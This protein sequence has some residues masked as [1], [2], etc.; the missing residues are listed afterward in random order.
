MAKATV[1]IKAFYR[2]PSLYSPEAL[3]AANVQESRPTPELW[4]GGI[5]AFLFFG[6][7]L[8]GA[9]LV[10]FD[11]AALGPGTLAVAGHRQTVQHRDGGSISALK[12]K[13]GQH[14]T[15]GQVLLEL[16]SA[17]VRNQE[18]SLAAQV[19]SLKAQRARLEAEVNGAAAI[20]WPV[21]F[22]ALSGA[23]RELALSAQ[24]L[25]Q[26]QFL[27]RATSMSAQRRVLGQR[28]VELAHQVE[29]YRGQ[30][31]SAERQ[32]ALLAEQLAS[33][34]ALEKQGYASVN[35]TRSL[36]R[37]IAAV[38]GARAQLSA[39]RL[40]TQK[41]IGEMGLQ[42]V[43]NDKRYGEVSSQELRDTLFQL[44]E[45][46]PKFR[47]AQD[48]LSRLQVKAPA[49][50]RVVGL[51]VFTVGGVISPGQSLMDIVPD[52]APLVVRA[53]FAPTDID[54]IRIGQM[55]EVRFASVHDRDLPMVKGAITNLSADALADEKTGEHYFA[56][57]ITVSPEELD[58]LRAARKTDLDLTPGFPA[59][60]MV[61]LRKRTAFEYLIE[62]LTEALKRSFGER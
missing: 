14:V 17:E 21:E 13:E 6:V 5:V 41:Q 38:E 60:V 9:N 32:K 42:A 58:R 19:I 48:A 20:R 54:G 49:T 29:G 1:P 28:K 59:Q 11:A 26:Q 56:A 62:P 24:R 36:Q 51:S 35:T 33:T 4:K 7:F 45:M 15:A 16:S 31:S 2:S 52:R 3:Q 10:R 12:V 46:E 61:P 22:Q 37:N 40:S 57:E 18:R 55:A 50:G 30:S 34:E 47:A 27:S 8:G 39:T 23:D 44:N 25:Q 53:N 43:Q